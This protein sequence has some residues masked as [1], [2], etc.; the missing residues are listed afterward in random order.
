MDHEKRRMTSKSMKRREEQV[1]DQLEVAL[2]RRDA[3]KFVLLH[4]RAPVHHLHREQAHNLQ[5]PKAVEVHRVDVA[6]YNVPTQLEVHVP[7]R[8]H[9]ER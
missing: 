2:L 7:E 1:V 9:G 8:R 6:A 5:Y 4:N 3:L